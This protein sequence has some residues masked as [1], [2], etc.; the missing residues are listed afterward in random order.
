MV[1]PAA[2]VPERGDV[3]WLDFTPHSGH[4]QGGRRPALVVSPSNYNRKTGLA[5]VFPITT[6]AKGYP[7]ETPLPTGLKVTGVILSDHLKNLDWRSRRALFI[8]RLDAS[9]LNDA[10]AKLHA[11]T[12]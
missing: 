8:C 1:M 7:F 6:H 12:G 10:L 3:M 11:L 5:L 2:Y 4:E 9:I